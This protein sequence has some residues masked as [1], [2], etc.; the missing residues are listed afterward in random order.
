MTPADLRKIKA[1]TGVSAVLSLQHDDCLGYWSIDYQEMS[2]YGARLGLHLVRCPMRDFDVADQRRRLAFAVAAL[3][4]LQAQ[5]HRTYVHCTAGLGRAPLTVLGYLSWVEE[6]SPDDAIKVIHRARP[7]AVPA[8]EAFHGCRN[9]MIQRYQ[10]RIKERAHEL[11]QA[12]AGGKGDAESDWLLA[13]QAI[14][15][16]ALLELNP[17]AGINY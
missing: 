15:K 2:A 12:R 14:I 10:W 11:Y 5:G 17:A 6:Q 7:G 9:D 1:T 8:W 13:E 4:N 3:S 16:S